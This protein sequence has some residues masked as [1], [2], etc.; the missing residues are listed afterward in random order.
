[1]VQTERLSASEYACYPFMSLSHNIF[2]SSFFEAEWDIRIFQDRCSTSNRGSSSSR[3][4]SLVV[5]SEPRRLR[6]GPRQH[7]RRNNGRPAVRE[8]GRDR[9]IVARERQRHKTHERCVKNTERLDRKKL[10]RKED[11]W[12]RRPREKY[13]AQGINIFS[14]S[15][16]ETIFTSSAE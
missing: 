16:A 10:E 7:W 13:G 15:L 4:I 5:E 9:S 11:G 2:S 1:M 3:S 12:R 6:R 14:R 8:N